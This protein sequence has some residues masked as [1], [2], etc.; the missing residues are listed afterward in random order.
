M[1]LLIYLFINIYNAL[2]FLSLMIT[3][4]LKFFFIICFCF[5]N[6]I[7]AQ[8]QDSINTSFLS[9]DSLAR[10]I[11]RQNNIKIFYN[12]TWFEGKEF[13]ASISS[14]PLPEA[15]SIIT[16][17]TEFS[18][19]KL[20]ESYYVFTPQS[21]DVPA[22]NSDSSGYYEIGNILDYGSKSSAI[23]NGAV[24]NGN[25]NLSIVG[26]KIEIVDLKKK[27]ESNQFGQFT[28]K[29][30]VGEHEL[31]IEY[32]GYETKLMK[33]KV[34]S[35][36]NITIEL[37]LKTILLDE[38][39]VFATKIDQYFRR[40]KMS[41][42]SMDAKTIKELP[43]NL[44][45]TDIIKG[46][47]LMPG[48]QTTGE[49]GSGFNVR[50]GASDQ[51]LVLLEEVPI[52]NSSHLFGLTS[53]IN[54]DGISNVTLYKG[55]I[56]V[57]YGERASSILSVKMG[58]DE[59]KKTTVKGG[60]GLINS[61]ISIEIPIKEKLKIIL[62]G[63]ASYSDWILKRLP[64]IEL[65]NSS[66]SFND[67]NLYTSYK[68]SKRDEVTLYL[69]NSNDKFRFSG[70][71][72]FYYGNKL[73]SLTY[74]H[75]FNSK[76]YSNIVA[77]ISNYNANYI[78]NDTLTPLTSYKISNSVLYRS[79]K[80]NLIYKLNEKH[81]L[82]IGA[83]SFIYNVEPG[84][85]AP[86][87]RLSEITTKNIQNENGIEWAGFIGDDFEVNDKLSFEFGVRYSNFVNLGPKIIYNYY[88]GVPKTNES[89]DDSVIY[90]SGKIIK[91]WSGIEPRFTLR[92]NLNY[93]NS[94]RASY[95]RINQFV[96]LISST[97]T[98]TPTDLWKLSDRHIKPLINDQVA[99]GYF[100]TQNLFEFSI[101][102]YYKKYKNILEY[103]N[104]A[105]IF[106]NNRIETELINAEG[107]S[108]GIEVYFKKNLGKLGGWISYTLSKSLRRTTS[109]H[110]SEQVNNN[111]WYADN[112]DRPHN[113]VINGGYH[114]NKR[115]K[116][117]I[118]F[119]YNTGRPVTLP[120]LKYT[121][122]GSQIVY[123]SDRNKYRMPDY[124]R[125]DISISQFENL[126]I[127][128]KWKSYWTF[129]LINVYGRKNAYSIYYKRDRSPYTYDGRSSLN[130]LFI[131]GRPLPTFTYNFLF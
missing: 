64:D 25:T 6:T 111:S 94:F 84:R 19:V 90:K 18:V 122:K 16:K 121:I 65:K 109:Q 100:N 105:T 21:L 27:F 8:E 46:L 37:M 47:S 63:R 115:W 96:N 30:P 131:I 93:F 99:I 81:I 66:A 44:G 5:C 59:L 117:G 50:G 38:V 42:T 103:K 43:T 39:S 12:P 49:F 83:N 54:P 10:E 128:K 129:S 112:M 23:I 45:E 118:T 123:Y 106:L 56:P 35:D 120:E 130:K 1:S 74:S 82:T 85:E 76:F 2:Q 71:Q 113:I 97:A 79:L 41:V 11:E 26:A 77:G 13:K 126:K 14:L 7:S 33:V 88:P 91:T 9:F 24:V 58:S 72:N 116:F 52:F 48:V 87:G 102:A 89:I 57:T 55:G 75:R 104:G 86:Y 114:L 31:K 36:G 40:T 62:G 53:I 125:L 95:N 69:Y 51:N 124:H 78:E 67:L 22:Q 17:I 20:K 32:P 127:H 4:F 29:M 61:K 92:Y 3:N 98:A 60:I 80:L 73:G 68:P 119:N 107:K 70:D 28:M 108:Y 110:P 15:I 34:L 101:E